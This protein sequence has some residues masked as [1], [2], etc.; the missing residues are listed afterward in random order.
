MPNSSPSAPPTCEDHYRQLQSQCAAVMA[1]SFD[2]DVSRLQAVSHN[3]VAELEEWL[4]ALASRPEAELFKSALRE[5][6]YS[7]L[8]LV[9]GQYRQAF[10]SLRLS[11]ELLL[12]AVH[13]SANE[14]NLRMWLLGR[15]DIVWGNI[16]SN[17]TGVL[18][19]QFVSVFFEELTDSAPAYLAMAEAVYRECSEYVHGN[20]RTHE[21]LPEGIEFSQSI[22]AKW[23]DKAK[24]IRLISSFALCV[25]YVQRMDAP[26]RNSLEGLLLQNLGHL[27][28]VRQIVGAPV[29]TPNA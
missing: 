26:T 11:F 14:L 5:Y 10:M 7:L 17:D 1:A 23:H 16:I 4:R 19:K 27:A 2:A 20:A 25:R 8:A 15:K 22:F 21:D 3:F 12:G 13:F 29:E 18:S 6:Q 24:S 9:Q 28:A